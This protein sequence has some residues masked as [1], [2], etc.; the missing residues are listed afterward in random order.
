MSR[1]QEIRKRQMAYVNTYFRKQNT[2]LFIESLLLVGYLDW[3]EFF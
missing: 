1:K 3:K 2:A